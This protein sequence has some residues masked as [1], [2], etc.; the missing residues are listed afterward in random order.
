[1]EYQ[2]LDKMNPAAVM[3]VTGDCDDVYCT[4]GDRLI[5]GI[6]ED[7]RNA[8]KPETT[9]LTTA[10]D[11]YLQDPDKTGNNTQIWAVEDGVFTRVEHEWLE[12]G[13]EED[14][15]EESANRLCEN[16]RPASG[17]TGEIRVT[18]AVPAS[19]VLAFVNESHPMARHKASMSETG[20]ELEDICYLLQDIVNVR[21]HG[22]WGNGG[23]VCASLTRLDPEDSS[24]V[25][26]VYVL[27]SDDAK[28]YLGIRCK[29]SLAYLDDGEPFFEIEDDLHIAPMVWGATDY[30]WLDS[31]AA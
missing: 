23:E 18:G 19:E 9:S 8:G 5:E 4:T 25:E 20:A 13:Y 17:N 14:E 2:D 29:G 11:A 28:D 15:D 21:G 26:L 1:M 12:E 27:A 24:K 16:A 31:D 30:V 10:L 22:E 7:L 3:V 6:N